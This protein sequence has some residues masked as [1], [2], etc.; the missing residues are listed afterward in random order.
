MP[1]ERILAGVAVVDDM[2]YVV[3]GRSGA[4][5][6]L[7]SPSVAMDQY[8]PIGYSTP[9]P[10]ASPTV[11]PSPVPTETEF[12]IAIVAAAVVVAMAVIAVIAVI[13]KRR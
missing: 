13:L 10:T 6:T 4:E 2:F 3:G 1:V 8:T 12:P 5:D 9:E 7:S 11:S